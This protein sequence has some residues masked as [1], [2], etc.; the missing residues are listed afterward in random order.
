VSD[1]FVRLIQRVS[2]KSYQQAFAEVY[3]TQKFLENFCGD[4]VRF[5]ARSFAVPGNHL[6]QQ[7]HGFRWPYGPWIDCT[8][9]FRL[10]VPC[11][12]F[13]QLSNECLCLVAII[14]P[15][16]FPLEIPVLQLMGA[17]YMGNKP[18]LKVDSKVS[19]VME[20]M[21]RL[22][23]SCGLPVEDVDFINCDG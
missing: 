5:L 15:F 6:G 20:Q 1:F 9:K 13:M 22:L 11:R 18:V 23:H 17:L 8:P 19:I 4:Q 21:L 10:A 2:P 7:S 14:T 16:N 3:V 12:F